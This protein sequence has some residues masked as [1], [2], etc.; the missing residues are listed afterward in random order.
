MRAK[1]MAMFAATIV[2]ISATAQN[3]RIYDQNIASLQVMSGSNWLLPPVIKL[4]SNAMANHL[5]VSF[6]DLTHSYRRLTYTIEHCEADWKTSK[7][8][9]TSDYLEGFSSGATIDDYQESINTNTLYTHYSLTIPNDH[10]R[11]KMSGNY[12]LNIFDE[13]NDMSPVL[14][15]CFMVVEPIVSLTISVSADTDIDVN[16]SHQQVSI[17]AVYNGLQVTDPQSQIKLTVMQ[18]GRTDN[19]VYNPQPLSYTQNNIAWNHNKD[20]IFPAGNEYRKFELLS[21]DHPTMGIEHIEWDGNDYHA[22]LHPAVPR[23]NY[24]YDEDA[25][26][27]FYIRN[28]DNVEN[29]I[30][31]DYAIIHFRYNCIQQK[32]GRIYV[33][34]IWTNNQLQSPY[35]LKYDPLEHFYHTAIRLKQGYYSYQY[36]LLDNDGRSWPMPA[37]GSFYQTENTYLALLYFRGHGERSDR[38]VGYEMI[39]N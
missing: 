2:T 34:G 14:S 9:F 29:E 18:N 7:E 33:N 23:Q 30:A 35:E 32:N 11:L 12:R 19:I 24:V 38:L 17:N 5:S 6:D 25:D 8:L 22:Y 39:K 21:L 13:D 36:V 10:C 16:K 15:A 31:S 27:S 1:I 26:G 37:E 3:N 20:L 28:S 4:G